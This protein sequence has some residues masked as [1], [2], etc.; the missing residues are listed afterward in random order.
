MDPSLIEMYDRARHAQELGIAPLLCLDEQTPAVFTTG[1]CRVPVINLGTAPAI[2]VTTAFGSI[3]IESIGVLGPR[4][5]WQINT[6]NQPVF[7][8]KWNEAFLPFWNSGAPTAE[9][10]IAYTDLAGVPYRSVVPCVRSDRDQRFVTK[11]TIAIFRD[12]R[13][14]A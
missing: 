14:M 9:L 12:G 3:P 7:A 13:R 1:T 10:V 11:K 2:N 6:D 5:A 4:Q 8:N